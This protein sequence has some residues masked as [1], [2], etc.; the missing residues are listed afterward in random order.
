MTVPGK[1]AP[2]LIGF[3]TPD[4]TPDTRSYL[5]FYFP[6]GN[7]WAG[8]LLGA[9]GAL[10]HHWNFYQWGALTADETSEIWREIVEQAP[11]NLIPQ[12]V[13]TP[14]WDD[15]T[16]VDDEEP[17]NDQAWYGYVDDASAPPGELTFKEEAF[18][19]GFAGLLAVAATPAAAIAF[20]TIARPFVLAAKADDLGELIRI[21]VNGT[22]IVRVDTTGRAGEV[23]EI[24]IV[25]EENPDGYDIL[26]IK[27]T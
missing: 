1:N 4:E 27:E 7:D 22:D 21:L 16:D 20:H 12:N 17:S 2:G 19:W 8:L 25:A 6:E 24:P 13:E 3:P 18:I 14:F 10:T 26:I 5:V 23:I 9:V 15:A 11:Y